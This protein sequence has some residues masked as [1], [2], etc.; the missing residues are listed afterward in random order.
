MAEVTGLLD[1]AQQ[2][3]RTSV[4]LY[5]TINHCQYRPR[6]AYQLANGASAL[7]VVLH[8]LVERLEA[9]IDDDLSSLDIP[10]KQCDKACQT[11]Q[12]QIVTVS[13]KPT[14]AQTSII[15]EGLRYMGRDIAYFIQLLA[16]Y[17]ITISIAL[18][19]ADLNSTS[20]I[21]TK[22][23]ERFNKL[24][25][26]ARSSLKDQLE[27][28]NEELGGNEPETASNTT[29]LRR[30][31]EEKLSTQKG[32]AICDRLSTRISQLQVKYAT[33][34]DAGNDNS[35]HKAST[36]ERIPQEE[37]P[38]ESVEESPHNLSHM[39]AE[40][41]ENEKLLFSL[42]RGKLMASSLTLEEAA[43]I[44]RLRG[45]WELIFKSRNILSNAILY[46]EKKTSEIVNYA[47]GD[48][49]QVIVATNGETL[50]GTN[51]GL[52]WRSRQIAGHFSDETMQQISRDMTAYIVEDPPTAPTDG[53]LAGQNLEFQE[54]Y[55]EGFKLTSMK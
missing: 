12:Q 7:I 31:K 29:E 43:D 24:L 48:A 53:K 9:S 51:R 5:E 10:L 45:E 33:D 44:D 55:G 21:T 30:I 1:L 50:N 19:V 17:E 28:I 41:V 3:V 36:P 46:S 37:K 18:T 40:L 26:S 49:H 2:A 11:F 4:G 22:N 47:T 34:P 16:N 20:S 14:N 38:Y 8:S 42:L 35:P 32:L 23:L 39:E 25:C 13:S 6:I 27:G 54:R 52:G 15:W